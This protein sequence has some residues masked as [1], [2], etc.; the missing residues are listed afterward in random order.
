MRISCPSSDIYRSTYQKITLFCPL[1][2]A[3]TEIGHDY[4]LP[5]YKLTA[6]YRP[7]KAYKG[8]CSGASAP[9]DLSAM[10]CF[11]D[12]YWN[13]AFGE[14]DKMAVDSKRPIR[15]LMTNSIRVWGT[16]CSVLMLT[17]VRSELGLYMLSNSDHLLTRF[18]PE[19]LSRSWTT[20]SVG[21]RTTLFYTQDLL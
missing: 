11:C 9:A 10:S 2:L 1:Q 7:A 13:V 8:M 4:V 20:V 14:T 5:I 19:D 21:V 3:S 12:R 15:R 6:C 17:D 18:L 16:V